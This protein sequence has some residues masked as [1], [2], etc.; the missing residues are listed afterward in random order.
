M[1]T[2]KFVLQEYPPRFHG[3]VPA[4]A[5]TMWKSAA[6]RPGRA[7]WRL[8]ASSGSASARELEAEGYQLAEHQYTL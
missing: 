1:R 8:S 3:V 2:Y 6:H 5:R 4:C 7:P